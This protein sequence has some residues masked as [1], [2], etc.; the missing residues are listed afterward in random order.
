MKKAF[1]IISLCLMVIAMSACFVACGGKEKKGDYDEPATKKR[2]KQ[3]HERVEVCECSQ[4]YTTTFAYDAE[5]H[6]IKETTIKDNGDSVVSIYQYSD[7]AIVVTTCNEYFD[8]TNSTAKCTLTDGLIT[9][10]EYITKIDDSPLFVTY[11]FEY[12]DNH[13]TQQGL[14]G[15]SAIITWNDGNITESMWTEPGSHNIAT[16]QKFTYDSTATTTL[17]ESWNVCEAF[18]LALFI[19]GYFGNGTKNRVI[20]KNEVRFGTEFTTTYTYETDSDGY[21][22]RCSQIAEYDGE[23]TRTLVWE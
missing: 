22:I 20:T 7:T 23:T 16:T 10:I 9:H 6:I 4:T 2:L 12:E 15:N 21:P 3:I 14:A 18:S 11:Y 17:V 8:G 19:Q 13:M 1:N 5:G